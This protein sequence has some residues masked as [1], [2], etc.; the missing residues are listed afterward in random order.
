MDGVDLGIREAMSVRDAVGR[1][2]EITWS[3]VQDTSTT[4]L[5]TQAYASRQLR[6]LAT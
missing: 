4:I 2:D 6:D 3:K 5:D 1:V